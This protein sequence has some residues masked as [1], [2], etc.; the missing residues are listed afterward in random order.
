VSGTTLYAGG[1]FTT[2]GGTT[3]NYI[4]QWDGTNWSSLGL[5]VSSGRFNDTSV[6]AL[7]A[8]GG[9]LYVGG[10]FIT[11]GSIGATNVASW[12][13]S[14]WSAIGP[15]FNNAV[16]ALAPSGNTLYAAGD[17]ITSGGKF[18]PFIAMANL[19]APLPRTSALLSGM[20]FILTWPANAT[21][22]T[23]QSTTNLVSPVVW[24]TNSLVPIVVNGQ[25][26]VSNSISGAQKFYRLIQ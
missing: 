8:S 24:T 25:N 20:N 18:C 21:G 5:G 12:D 23:L 6:T 14:S 2:A 9:T 26:T 17:F 11:A 4:A 1:E 19:L 22:F 7:T 3:A 16:N 10:V 13:G 15:G